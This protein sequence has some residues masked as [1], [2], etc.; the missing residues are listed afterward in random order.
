VPNL[1]SYPPGSIFMTGSNF[2]VES[3]TSRVRAEHSAAMATK[4]LS[5]T[6]LNCKMSAGL[7]GSKSALVTAGAQMAVGSVSFAMS[8]NRASLYS[9]TYYNSLTN[10]LRPGARIHTVSGNN[11]GSV[12]VTLETRL[13]TDA[14]NSR[15]TSDTSLSVKL[16]SG[17]AYQRK[18]PTFHVTAGIQVESF[19]KALSYD[20]ASVSGLS[21]SNL[22]AVSF[23][24]LIALSGINVGAAATSTRASAG[25][26]ACSVTHWDS[27]SSLLIKL[28]SGIG[29]WK[30]AFFITIA[31]TSDTISYAFSYDAP[32]Q[33]SFTV[34]NGPAAAIYQP[35]IFASNLGKADYSPRS[36]IG[37]SATRT[38]DWTSDTAM[39]VTPASGLMPT[40]FEASIVLTVGV[41]CPTYVDQKGLVLALALH[42]SLDCLATP[43][44]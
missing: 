12:Q 13:S 3:S 6:L 37:G 24:T 4:W 44:T 2:G 16:S 29:N 33:S 20:R 32:S 22:Q 19:S 34:A 39:R 5:S 11:F 40:H 17:H 41:W 36:S 23:L 28:A 15:W 35:L 7:A 25:H 21:P 43:H 26:S 42:L 10:V 27:T 18:T 9:F 14:E 8:Y 31:S 30:E 38:T 1:P